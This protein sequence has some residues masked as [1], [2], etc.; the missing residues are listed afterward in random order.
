[1]IEFGEHCQ[2]LM[3]FCD[4]GGLVDDELEDAGIAVYQAADDI[5]SAACSFVA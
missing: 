2:P 4:V 5:W 3:D 1:M